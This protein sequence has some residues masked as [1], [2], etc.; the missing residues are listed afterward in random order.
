MMRTTQFNEIFN[1]LDLS[2]EAVQ[3]RREFVRKLLE[4]YKSRSLHDTEQQFLKDEIRI[5]MAAPKTEREERCAQIMYLFYLSTKPISY[6]QLAQIYSIDRKTVYDSIKSAI[7]EFT[8]CIFGIEGIVMYNRR[9]YE[10]ECEER[11]ARTCERVCN[12]VA[13]ILQNSTR[14]KRED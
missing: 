13:A 1:S 2:A 8:V 7:E 6:K 5:F 14:K 9:A 10:K 12:A 11:Q 4:G 3:G